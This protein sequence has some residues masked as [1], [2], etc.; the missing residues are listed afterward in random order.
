MS[1][2]LPFCPRWTEVKLHLSG[3]RRGWFVREKL[4]TVR[5]KWERNWKRWLMFLT[6]LYSHLSEII[7]SCQWWGK[8][9]YD[10]LILCVVVYMNWV[11]LSPH[12]PALHQVFTCHWGS[13]HTM[14]SPSTEGSPNQLILHWVLT[15]VVSS[16]HTRSSLSLVFMHNLSLF[17]GWEN[18]SE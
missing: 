3:K 6:F 12:L 4:I 15:H 8:L 16:S 18:K 11:A 2:L 5:K 1:A 7:E 9:F 17:Y 10:W 13:P 14:C